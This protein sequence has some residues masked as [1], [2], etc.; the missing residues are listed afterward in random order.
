MIAAAYLLAIACYWLPFRLLWWV[1]VLRRWPSLLSTNRRQWAS[2][3]VACAL[4]GAGH[5]FA[6]MG[7][8]WAKLMRD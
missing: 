2:L 8:E 6:F 4:L 5:W 3:P 7:A 1:F